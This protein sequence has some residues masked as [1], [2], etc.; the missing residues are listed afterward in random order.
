MV[1]IRP[2][3]KSKR[4]GYFKYKIVRKS[5]IF[6]MSYVFSRLNESWREKNFKDYQSWYAADYKY[7]YGSII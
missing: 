3:I 4:G 5:A 7:Y 6:D 1:R 2:T